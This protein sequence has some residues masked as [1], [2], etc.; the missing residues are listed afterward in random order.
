MKT[1]LFLPTVLLLFCFAT[2]TAQDKTP[3]FTF[4]NVDGKAACISRCVTSYN[5]NLD[6]SY[7][8]YSSDRDPCKVFI[9]VGTSSDAETGGVKVDYTVDNTPATTYGV[10]AGDIILAL[11]GVSV[12]TQP[13]LV[14][15]RDKHQQGETF[16]LSILRD[17]NKMDINA[18]FKSC[19]KE[20]QDKAQEM[21]KMETVER[22]ILGIYEDEGN[23]AQG[24]VI[25]ETI[26]GKGADLAGLKSGD[27]ITTVEGQ[28]ISGVGALHNTL[29]SHKPGD[30]VVVIYQR[31]GQTQ[32]S[33]VTLSADRGHF[34]FNEKRDPCAVFIG[35]YVSDAMAGDNG[36]RITGIVDDTPAKQSN[37]QPGDVI[38]A[39]DGMAV[40]NNFE[41]RRERDKHQPGEQFRLTVLRNAAEMTIDATFKSCPK[42]N[43]PVKPVPEVV[44]L[45]PQVAPV[46]K[47][48]NKPSTPD[49]TLDLVVLDLFPNPT[50]DVLNIRFEAEAIPTT[51]RIADAS[52]RTIYTKIMGEFSGSFNEQVNLEGKAP[53][54]YTLTVQQGKKLISKN[55]VLLSRV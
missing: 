10:K 9:G 14:R 34:S 49:M 15:E 37:L 32:Q 11:D 26:P 43:E 7:N 28:T 12:S 41:L 29:S 48:E 35:V 38:L 27:V 31:D 40:N 1:R 55:I 47:P 4:K 36:V 33:K 30:Q 16:A 20:E 46:V 17:G 42:T 8:S 50:I 21:A 24:L 2:L 51:V 45:A 6:H 5:S 25:G 23:D 3:T 19:T 44:Q 54:T 53:G 52:G 13:E 18:R 22:P 39:L